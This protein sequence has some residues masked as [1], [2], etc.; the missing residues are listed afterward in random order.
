VQHFPSIA[1]GEDDHSYADH[2]TMLEVEHAKIVPDARNVAELMAKTFMKRR[3][4]IEEQ[5]QK[6][7]D[8]L[9]KYPFLKRLDIV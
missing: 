3:K 2:M 5:P 7:A 6:V 1:I 8:L 4:E 9:R